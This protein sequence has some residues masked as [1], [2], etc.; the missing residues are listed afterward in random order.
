MELRSKRN[1][2]DIMVIWHNRTLSH[3]RSQYS[4]TVYGLAVDTT[5]EV[6]V[7]AHS[8]IGFG[9]WSLPIANTTFGCEF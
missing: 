9:L 5:Y 3:Y 4:E 7:R 1:T 8:A 6:H 2:S